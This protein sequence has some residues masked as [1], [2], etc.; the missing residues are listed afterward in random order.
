M[1]SKTLFPEDEFDNPIDRRKR[2]PDEEPMPKPYHNRVA[3][4]CDAAE[5]VRR[6]VNPQAR[7]VFDFI[8]SR[9]DFGATDKE[10][11]TALGMSGDSQRPRRVWLRDN[12]F[13]QAKG[14]PM[15]PELRQRSI[16]WVATGKPL[17]FNDA[18]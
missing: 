4:S 16:V 7:R 8:E 15:R 14:N 5:R 3:T 18:E 1:K 2:L 13:V 11:Q 12:G 9:G 17:K 10:Q 6:S